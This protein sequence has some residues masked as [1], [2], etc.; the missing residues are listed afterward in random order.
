MKNL[1]KYLLPVFM[2]L[3]M[4]SPAQRLQTASFKWQELPSI[5]DSVGFAGSFA[6]ISNGSLLVAGGANFPD[7]GTPWTGSRKV[8]TDKI[9]VLNKQDGRWKVVGKLPRPLGYG[10]SVTWNDYLLCIGGSNATGHFSDVFSISYNGKEITIDSLPD[11]PQTLANSCGALLGNVVYLAGGLV[12]PDSTAASSLFCS[13]DLS[14]FGAERMTWK[15]HTTW[16]GSPRM[17]SVAGIRG[18]S[19]FLFSGAALQLKNE[20]QPE[21]VYLRDAFKYTPGKGWKKL[22]NLPHPVV[23][24]PGPAYGTGDT[25]LILG[26][27]DGNLALKAGELKE[28]HPGFSTEILG[29]ATG[30]NKW[31]SYGTIKTEKKHDGQNNPNGSV[32]APVTTPLVVWNGKLVFTGGEVRPAVRTPRIITAT[33][34]ALAN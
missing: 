5:P 23:A 10:V 6:G 31:F 14:K 22:R 17:L 29:Y 3:P 32:W 24:A 8:W 13:L 27:D 4:N 1:H 16:P 11:L 9:F 15:T 18:A 20:Q 26:G 19:F 30:T 25:L 21:R 12:A 2:A 34:A 33:P 28:R 7:G